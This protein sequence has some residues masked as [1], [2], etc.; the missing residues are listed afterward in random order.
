MVLRTVVSFDKPEYFQEESI[1]GTAQSEVSL[2]ITGHVDI[3]INQ[4]QAPTDGRRDEYI[5][6]F[7][8]S[9]QFSFQQPGVQKTKLQMWK[10]QGTP[11]SGWKSSIVRDASTSLIGAGGRDILRIF[12]QLRGLSI[13]SQTWP[14]KA[15]SK[16]SL[17]FRHA[18]FRPTGVLC[19]SAWQSEIGIYGLGHNNGQESE[20]HVVWGLSA[21]PI[22]QDKYLSNAST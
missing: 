8:I 11:N 15:S 14:S 19:L 5:C 2:T 7:K 16:H 9:A 17:Q 20:T 6:K 21:P 22:V 12:G 18:S 4:Y 13:P 3:D 10:G 1:R